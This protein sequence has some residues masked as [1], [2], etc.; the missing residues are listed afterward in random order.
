[1]NDIDKRLHALAN[2][3]DESGDEVPR[4]IYNILSELLEIILLMRHQQALLNLS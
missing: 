1:M 4:E 3:L 2:L